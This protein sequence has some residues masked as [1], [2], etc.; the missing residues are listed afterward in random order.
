[1]ISH[2]KTKS[3]YPCRKRNTGFL[4]QK[5]DNM[6]QKSYLYSEIVLNQTKKVLFVKRKTKYRIY[7]SIVTLSFFTFI[8][9]LTSINPPTALDRTYPYETN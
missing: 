5:V 4:P 2:L 7:M 3:L 9:T 8:F 6:Y 1:M